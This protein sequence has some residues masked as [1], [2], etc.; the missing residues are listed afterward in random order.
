MRQ[1][2]RTSRISDFAVD[3]ILNVGQCIVTDHIAFEYENGGVGI[4]EY[5]I[6]GVL[7]RIKYKSN[8]NISCSYKIKN[9]DG[10]NVVH[11]KRINE[12][13]VEWIE[14]R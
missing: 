13:E 4:L 6:R 11:F 8:G 12:I 7:D 1:T 3:Q 14:V 9:L 5:F 2:G 10:I